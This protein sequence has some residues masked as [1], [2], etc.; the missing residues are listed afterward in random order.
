VYKSTF[1]LIAVGI[2][3]AVIRLVFDPSILVW[4][5]FMGRKFILGPHLGGLIIPIFVILAS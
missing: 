4:F 2:R 3:F 5:V 1:L